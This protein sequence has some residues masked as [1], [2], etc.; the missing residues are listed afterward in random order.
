MKGQTLAFPLQSAE[1]RLCD[2]K[3]RHDVDLGTGAKLIFRC[4]HEGA[5]AVMPITSHQFRLHD[6]GKGL[7]GIAVER[8]EL[9]ICCRRETCSLG[10]FMK[11]GGALDVGAWNKCQE[12]CTGRLCAF[13]V[14]L[15]LP[16][17]VFHELLTLLHNTR[18]AASTI[19]DVLL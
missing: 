19:A 15:H 18:S 6:N 16:G 4:M 10:E 14:W 12:V 5:G 8:A 3:E 7:V 17:N 13:S 1:Q 2:A 9:H 11:P